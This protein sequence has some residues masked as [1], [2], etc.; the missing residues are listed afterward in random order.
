MRLFDCWANFPFTT[1][2][3][4]IRVNLR[5][6]KRLKTSG[7]YQNITEFLP[8]AQSSYRNENFVSTR[9][10]LLRNR[11]WT[12]PVVRYFTWKL[13]FV[14]NILWVNAEYTLKL[15]KTISSAQKTFSF[16]QMVTADLLPLYHL[17]LCYCIWSS[18]QKNKIS[19]LVVNVDKPI[20][21]FSDTAFSSVN[22]IRLYFHI[23]L[24]DIEKMVKHTLKTV[25]C[26]HHNIF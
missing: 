9:K 1:S 2:E 7:K 3:R 5:D 17:G 24:H 22:I 8:S 23:C 16:L 20:R 18:I 11:Y 13:E 14:S 10:N 25:Q 6:A 21:I 19:S 26:L 4:Y 12:F 15:I